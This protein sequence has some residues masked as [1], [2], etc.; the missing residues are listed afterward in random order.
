MT[1]QDYLLAHGQQAPPGVWHTERNGKLRP[2]DVSHGSHKKVWWQCEKGHDW[3]A[4]VFSVVLEGCGCPYCNGKKAL[5]GETDLATLHPQIAAEWDFEKN[6]DLQPSQIL[7]SSH[8]K[9]WWRCELG[10]S[11]EAAPFSRTK[12]NGT[13]CP[14]CA[15]RK[16]LKGFNDLKTLRLFLAKEWYQPLNGKLR[17]TEVTVGSNKKVWWRCHQGHVWQAAIYARAKENGTG[18]PVCMGVAKR[19]HLHYWDDPPGA[20]RLPRPAGL[21]IPAE[22]VQIKSEKPASAKR[23]KHNQ[24]EAV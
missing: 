18:C 19:S 15:G 4:P 21:K 11:Y 6:G 13:G 3:Q 5:A 23:K 8:V 22:E 17:P 1:L 24:R 2:V 10:H 9:I 14:Y 20:K 7:P 12:E 16:V